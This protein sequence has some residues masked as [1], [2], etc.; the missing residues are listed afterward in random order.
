MSSPQHLLA[1][2]ALVLIFAGHPLHAQ[3]GPPTN[4]LRLWLEADAGV[5][6][7]QSGKISVWQ[8]QSGL[9]NDATETSGSQQPLLVDDSINGLPTVHFSGGQK[10]NL[11]NLMN[12]ANGGEVSWF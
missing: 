4:G 6:H 5:V 3:S 9:G 12:G 2:A 8:D 7:D 1:A 11:P 10:L